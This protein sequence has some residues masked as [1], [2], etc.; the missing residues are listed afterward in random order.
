MHIEHIRPT[1]LQVTLHPY[2]LAALVAAARWVVAGAEG[3]L[4]AE[5]VEQLKQVLASYDKA[6]R[7]ASR[8][9]D[10]AAYQ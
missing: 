3:E 7:E 6:S 4:P 9:T 1:R 8:S 5:A 10:L 2:E